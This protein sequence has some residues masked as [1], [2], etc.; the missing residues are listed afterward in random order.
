MAGGWVGGE[1]GV[2][3]FA[4]RGENVADEDEQDALAPIIVGLAVSAP[5]A[6]PPSPPF[7]PPLCELA[8]YPRPALR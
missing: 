4:A 7:P 2:K 3:Q 8:A 1:R 5:P 6:P